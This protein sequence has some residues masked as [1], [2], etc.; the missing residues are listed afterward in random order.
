MQQIVHRHAI[1][2]GQTHQDP[3]RVALTIVDANGYGREVW[4]ARFEFPEQN[5]AEALADFQR[6]GM[7]A[8]LQGATSIVV[9]FA[10]GRQYWV[11]EIALAQ[12]GALRLPAPPTSR[13]RSY[14]CA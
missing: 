10:P 6:A 14:R 4:S 7:K 8:E 9:E 11:A 12:E 13:P 3:D 5:V 2:L 1:A